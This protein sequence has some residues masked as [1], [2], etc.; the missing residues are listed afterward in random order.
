MLRVFLQTQITGFAEA[1]I[2][3]TD[4]FSEKRDESEFS[5]RFVHTANQLHVYLLVES[6]KFII[7]VGLNR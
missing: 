6:A 5:H 4:N 7:G 2:N 3:F 1:V